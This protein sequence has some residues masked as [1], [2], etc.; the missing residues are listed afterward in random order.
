MIREISCYNFPGFYESIFC[1]SD[2][3]I[4]D[5][6]ELQ[7]EL[8][9]LVGEG[10]IEVYYEYDDFDKYKLDVGNKFMEYYIKEIK[11]VLPSEITD[12]EEFKLDKID[13]SISVS[14]PEY[15]NYRTDNCYCEIETNSKTLNLIKEHTL[16]LEGVDKY[17]K[18]HFTS[19]DGFI[20][21][22]SND[23]NYWKSLDI[24]EYETNMLTSLLD[25]LISLSPWGD[26]EQITLGTYYDIDKYYYADATI[27]YKEK[28]EKLRKKGLKTLKENGYKING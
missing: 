1:H 10:K 8:E 19:C 4:D 17:I 26:F 13:Y 24:E 18:S 2:E 20:S 25:M 12:H 7:W 15:Y 5:E 27:E 21:F 11:K 23:I 3:F 16:K 9:S 6:Y 14:S 22:I 28:N